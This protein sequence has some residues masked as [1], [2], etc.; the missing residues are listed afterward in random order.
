MFLNRVPTGPLDIE[1]E[2]G[3]SQPG[4]V[5]TGPLDIEPEVVGVSQLGGYQQSNSK[6]CIIAIQ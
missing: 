4:T 5:P 3:V 1:P 6:L 2:D